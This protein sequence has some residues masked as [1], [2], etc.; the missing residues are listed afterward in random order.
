MPARVFIDETEVVPL[1]TQMLLPRWVMLELAGQI[2]G[3]RANVSPVD[4]PPV[5]GFETWRWGTRFCREHPELRALGWEVCE[6]DQVSGI[7]NQAL[8]LKLVFCNTDS[9]TGKL[10]KS[11][12][13]TNEKGP[14]SCRLIGRN[15]GQLSLPL[16]EAPE[17]R[18]CDLWY[19]CCHF[20]DAYIAI[21]VSRPSS[22][23]GGIVTGFS[24]RI[25]IAKPHEIPGISRNVVPEEFADV[26]KPKVTRKR[27]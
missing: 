5:V 25:I 13:N 23:I 20:C 12:K 21:E 15:S 27:G 4:A 3:E 8:K 17:K 26:P 24:D 10:A 6:E 9:N 19:F 16:S 18:P 22:E 11:P 14:A 2:A 1:L 7:K